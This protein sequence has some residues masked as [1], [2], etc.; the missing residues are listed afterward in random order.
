[1]TTVRKSL[2]LI[3]AVTAYSSVAGSKERKITDFSNWTVNTPWTI[4]ADKQ[5]VL[6]YEGRKEYRKLATKFNLDANECYKLTI[7]FRYDSP[8]QKAD[9]FGK[10]GSVLFNLPYVS[11]WGKCTVYLCT[12]AK[13]R[14]PFYITSRGKQ[15]FSARIRSISIKK[16]MPQDLSKIVFSLDNDPG[17]EPIEFKK[18]RRWIKGGNDSAGTVV[19]VKTMDHAKAGKA[20]KIS[21]TGK[22]QGFDRLRIESV[23]VPVN[24]GG[25]YKMS[26][27]FKSDDRGVAQVQVTSPWKHGMK[28][29]YKKQNFRVGNQWVK[30]SFEFSIPEAKPDSSLK[31]GMIYL[32]VG[33]FVKSLNNLYVKD[34][35][36]EKL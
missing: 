36:W 16:M 10:L 15:A 28:Q 32:S 7:E 4:N 25:K 24:P 1:M 31:D 26:G 22:L 34:I 11:D 14:Y 12:G 27:W 30:Q 35:I 3:L 19:L 8:G 20:M 23:L 17:P 13:G 9:L 6:K 33:L 5:A 21:R 2:I 18:E 29:W